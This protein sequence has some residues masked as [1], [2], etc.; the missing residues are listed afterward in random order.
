MKRLTLIPLPLLCIAFCLSACS[1]KDRGLILESETLPPTGNLIVQMS[2]S[3][4]SDQGAVGCGVML[5]GHYCS[6]LNSGGCV[7]MNVPTGQHTVALVQLPKDCYATDGT[8]RT[9]RV[10]SDQTSE[11]FFTLHCGDAP[12]GGRKR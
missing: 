3:G 6:R 11:V 2:T 10:R 5:D 12:V 9:V 8:S 4:T 1:D 7:T